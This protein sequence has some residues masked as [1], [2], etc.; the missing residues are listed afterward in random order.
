MATCNFAA[1]PLSVPQINFGRPRKKQYR[2]ADRELPQIEVQRVLSS[3][4]ESNDD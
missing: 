4:P 2:Q 3:M 1:L